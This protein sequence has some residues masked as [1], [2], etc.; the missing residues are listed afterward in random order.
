ML[1]Q[2]EPAQIKRIN[3]GCGRNIIPG[4]INLDVTALPGVDVVAD[5]ENCQT[6]PLPFPDNFFD[7]ILL[8]HVLEHIHNCMPLMQELHRIAK[9]NAVAVIR[10][11]YGSSDDAY[12]DPTHVRIFFSKSFIYF[13]Q[14]TYWKADYGYRGD[15]QIQTLTFKVD[16]REN[17]GISDKEILTRI[18][19]FRNIVKEM[20]AK[21]VA[22]KPIRAPKKELQIDAKIQI[23]LVNVV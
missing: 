23:V 3:V 8:S 5:L 1:M 21:L 19:I 13:S 10:V 16:R 9:P 14:P 20:E 6:Q 15:W 22:I 11:P 4:W 7:E 2:M 18:S 17:K 12:E